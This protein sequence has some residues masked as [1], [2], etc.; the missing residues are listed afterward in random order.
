MQHMKITENIGEFQKFLESD[1]KTGL[2]LE[3]TMGF[4]DIQRILGQFELVKQRG[5]R[6]SMIMTNLYAVLPKQEHPQLLFP[7]VWE[8]GSEKRQYEPLL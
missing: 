6:V 1:N 7:T 3:D 5:I 2:C 8:T 4:F